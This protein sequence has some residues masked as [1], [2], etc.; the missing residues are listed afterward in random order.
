MSTVKNTGIVIVNFNSAADIERCLESLTKLTEQNFF[1]VIVDSC[2]SDGSGKI[3]QAKFAGTK[4]RVILSP[5]NQGFAAACNLGIAY[6]RAYGAA[7]TWLLNPDTEVDPAALGALLDELKKDENVA[8][9]GSKI[10]YPEENGKQILWGA[11][12]KID[13]QNRTIAMI[14]SGEEDTGKY[15]SVADCDYLPGCSLLIRFSAIETIGYLPEDYFMYFEETDWCVRARQ[16]GLLL[17]YVPA[18]VV[19]HH[20]DDNKMQKPFGVYYYNR[21][22]YRFWFQR[23]AWRERIQLLA[24]VKFKELPQNIWAYL[25]A[26]SNELRDIF[27]AHIA[28]CFDFLLGRGGIDARY[29]TRL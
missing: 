27:R 14:G 4:I 10:L 26:P 29:S 28:A 15:N 16:L 3:L 22:F 19:I 8:A 21:N 6:A 2:S 18:S 24:F 25:H 1:I 9:V 7:H 5:Q 23:S 20:F 13:F 11:G 17:R 12:G